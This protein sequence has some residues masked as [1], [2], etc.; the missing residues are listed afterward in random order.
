MLSDLPKDLHLLILEHDEEKKRLKEENER[1]KAQV[2]MTQLI[3]L[4][5][6]R[7]G[8]ASSFPREVEVLPSEMYRYYKT[9][10]IVQLKD[11]VRSLGLSGYGN[12]K[13]VLIKRLIEY[14]LD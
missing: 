1:L 12:S 4:G 3:L 6:E 13:R 10:G 2:K 5:P 7:V 9:F 11:K 14:Y 8:W